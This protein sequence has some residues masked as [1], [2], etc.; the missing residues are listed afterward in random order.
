MLLFMTAVSGRSCFR[1]IFQSFTVVLDDVQVLFKLSLRFVRSLGHPYCWNCQG[2]FSLQTSCALCLVF[3]FQCFWR[4]L[5]WCFFFE[6]LL[7]SSTA[8][9]LGLWCRDCPKGNGVKILQPGRGYYAA[10]QAISVTSAGAKGRVLFCQVFDG[11]HN[12]VK[13]NR[14]L[15]SRRK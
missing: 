3:G 10:T 15:A 13:S 12:L 1:A 11:L 6:F 5:V 9:S 14:I 7:S 8:I 2:V 4:L